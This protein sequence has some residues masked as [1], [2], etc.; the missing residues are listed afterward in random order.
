MDSVCILVRELAEASLS[1]ALGAPRFPRRLYAYT[2]ERF[3]LA[4]YALATTL[5]FLSA[6][7]C[8]R[9][10]AGR[11][12]AFGAEAV[13]GLVTVFLLFL[14]LRLLDEF[15]DERFDAEHYPERPVPR[16]LVTLAELRVVGLVI[17]AVQIVLNALLGAR[18]LLLVVGAL[19]FTALTAREFF[20]GERLRR[21][22][23]HYTLAH[24]TV[25]PVL[26]CYAYGLAVLGSGD[27]AF[28]PGFVLFLALSYLAGLLL[29]LTRKTRAP[30]AERAGVYSYTKHLGRKGASDLAVGIVAAASACCLGLGLALGFGFSYH[31]AI[32]I[33]CLVAAAGFVRFRFSPTTAAADRIAALYA[34]AYVLG[35]YGAI[36]L[37]VLLAA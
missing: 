2:R 13:I 27:P 21:N 29:E 36:I 33:L 4:P 15:K 14:Q 18:I 34:P 12:A 16:G 10:L 25:L 20:V 8:G 23:L 1:P 22:F 37:Q 26:A 32:W 6:Y 9:A 11:P 19:L 31:A 17:V 3:P 7:L 24:L 30:E 28:K 35:V 5:F